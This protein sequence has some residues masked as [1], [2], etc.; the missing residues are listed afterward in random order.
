MKNVEILQ[1]RRLL[2]AFFKVDEVQLRHE[3]FDGSMSPPLNRLCFERGDGVA[4]LLY[5]PETE[6]LVLVRQFRYPTLEAG[7]GWIVELVAGMLDAAEAPE[8]TMRREILEET[9]YVV[10]ELAFISMFYLSPGG[11]SERIHLYCAEVD[12]AA[13][14]AE[15]GG[16]EVALGSVAGHRPYPLGVTAFGESGDVNALYRKHAIDAEAILDMAALA[17]LDA[18]R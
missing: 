16:R 18:A 8:E 7:P 15:G 10:E 11:S 1:E 9:G 4:A 13:R 2:D 12:A 17:C 6:R 14:R 3:R 5:A